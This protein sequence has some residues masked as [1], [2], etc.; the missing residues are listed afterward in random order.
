MGQGWVVM[1]QSVEAESASEDHLELSIEGRRI[2]IHQGIVTAEFLSY[3]QPNAT[4]GSEDCAEEAGVEIQGNGQRASEVNESRALTRQHHS[5]EEETSSARSSVPIKVKENLTAPAE[6]N[7][8]VNQCDDS[9]SAP[10]IEAPSAPVQTSQPQPAIAS[11]SQPLAKAGLA[12]EVYS[13]LENIHA[14]LTGIARHQQLAHLRFVEGQLA[15]ATILKAR[16]A[17][18]VVL[19]VGQ[20]KTINR[21]EDLQEYR[22][23]LRRS[24][25]KE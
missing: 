20:Y 16:K 6:D 13:M 11:T 17:L 23:E 8:D 9:L 18:G 21:E 12:E 1:T 5:P 3:Y 10:A 7:Q 14:P 2:G 22:K 4:T 25:G 15:E 19:T 24:L